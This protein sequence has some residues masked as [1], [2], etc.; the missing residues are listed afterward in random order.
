[1]NSSSFRSSFIINNEQIEP[2]LNSVFENKYGKIQ[3]W[4]RNYNKFWEIKNSAISLLRIF[5]YNQSIQKN[6]LLLGFGFDYFKSHQSYLQFF[7][8]FK[9]FGQ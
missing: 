2:N 3:C 8:G 5:I 9:V 7:L 1:M 6:Y 4:P